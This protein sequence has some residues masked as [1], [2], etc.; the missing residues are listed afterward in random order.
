MEYE[1]LSDHRIERYSHSKLKTFEQCPYQYKLHY[2]DYPPV[3]GESN[4]FSE[5]GSHAHSI[6]ERHLRGEIQQFEMSSVFEEEFAEKVPSGVSIVF[7]NGYRK[8]LTDSYKEQCKLFFDTFEGFE[9]YEVVGIEEGFNY[10]LQLGDKI[11]EVTG[12]IDVI[13]EDQLLYSGLEIQICVR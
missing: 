9:G 3:E 7:E 11:S 12:I 6:L 2:V 8:Y 13:L 1:I 4:G 5:L 10:V